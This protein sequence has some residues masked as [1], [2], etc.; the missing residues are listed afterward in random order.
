MPTILILRKYKSLWQNMK[1]TSQCYTI[2][3]H[4]LSVEIKWKAS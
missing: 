3:V 4:D 2:R 1:L